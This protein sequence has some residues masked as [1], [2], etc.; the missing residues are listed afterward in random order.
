MSSIIPKSFSGDLIPRGMGFPQLPLSYRT[1]GFLLLISVEVKFSLGLFSSTSVPA[2]LASK[3]AAILG[4]SC[5]GERK[6]PR[7]LPFTCHGH[8]DE[9]TKAKKGPKG[10]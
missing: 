9:V 5:T 2:V 3:F 4:H 10:A 6:W 8:G 1:T 7:E